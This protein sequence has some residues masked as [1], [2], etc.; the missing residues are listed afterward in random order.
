V[1]FAAL[2]GVTGTGQQA[3]ATSLAA[4]ARHLTRAA[5][6]E[7]RRRLMTGASRPR[8]L[9][10]WLRAG[11]DRDQM[12]PTPYSCLAGPS[13]TRLDRRTCARLRRKSTGDPTRARTPTDIEAWRGSWD[14]A[15]QVAAPLTVTVRLHRAG[16]QQPTMAQIRENTRDYAMPRGY[17]IGGGSEH[18]PADREH[19]RGSGS[20][21]REHLVMEGA[22]R[23][24][25][26]AAMHWSMV[27]DCLPMVGPPHE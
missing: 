2:L 9:A 11:A 22:H 3:H 15:P 24:A 20:G 21:R 17:R 12:P 6:R 26:R 7:A 1:L 13:R 10:R 5:R 27:A 16:H 14:R 8:A 23:P 19:G 18:G 25:F 4:C